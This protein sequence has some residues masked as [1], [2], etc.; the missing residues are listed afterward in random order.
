M[1]TALGRDHPAEM[2][3][4]MNERDDIVEVKQILTDNMDIYDNTTSSH[5]P[6]EGRGD[7]RVKQKG[8]SNFPL[9]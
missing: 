1:T 7:A 3:V 6:V 9:C 5:W 2:S 4:K 8:K